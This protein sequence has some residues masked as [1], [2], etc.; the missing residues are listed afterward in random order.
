MSKKLIKNAAARRAKIIASISALSSVVLAGAIINLTTATNSDDSTVENTISSTDTFTTDPTTNR[1]LIDETIYVFTKSDGTVRKVISSDWTKN[2]GIDEFTKTE[3]SDKSTPIDVKISYKLNGESIDATQLSGKSGRVTIRFDYTNKER[4]G[5][6]Y[7]PYAVLTGVVLDNVDF[8]NIEVTNGKSVNDGNRTIVAGF[9]LPGMKENL[10]L[11]SST[12]EI[13]DYVEISADT[14][15]FKLRTT[16]SLATSEIFSNIDTS[17]LDSA[18]AL[19]SELTKLTNAFDQIIGGSSDL[20]GGIDKLY[21]ET[22]KLQDGVAAL[23]AGSSDLNTGIAKIDQGMSD[24]YA[25]INDNFIANNESLQNGATAIFTSILDTA[26]TKIVMSLSEKLVPVL[27]NK[28]YTEAAAKAKVESLIPTFTIANYSSE[29]DSVMTNVTAFINDLPIS[30]AEKAGYLTALSGSA[31]ELA[32]AKAQLAEVAKFHAGVYS[33]TNGIAYLN[34]T[35][36]KGLKDDTE[37]SLK[38]GTSALLAGSA[39]LDDGLSSLNAATPQLIDGIGQLRDGSAKLKDGLRQFNDEGIS[40]LVNTYSNIDELLT[41]V[42]T[43]AN[44][45]KDNHKPIKYI[46]RTDEIK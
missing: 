46:Y 39:K 43:I 34:E 38:E 7:V 18:S 4:S 26:R 27:V 16:V 19:S 6:Y 5:S 3:R 36:I 1:Q 8:K 42:K 21:T 24:L 2:L 17:N 31:T 33:Y 10:G 45:A 15:S 13:P 9:A 23:K 40:K 35:K 29:I 37:I 28:G 22:A 30:D 11:T 20:Y 14:E 41:R 25:G 12:Y 44:I 32:N